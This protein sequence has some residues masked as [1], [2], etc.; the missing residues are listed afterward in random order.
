[1]DVEKEAK[2]FL[3]NNVD[4]IATKLLSGEKRFV[5]KK[6]AYEED[7]ENHLVRILLALDGVEQ[8]MP[9]KD[10]ITVITGRRTMYGC[11]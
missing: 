6:T 10:G 8:A 5:I 1:M 11:C 9:D 3:L 4:G 7:W 2:K